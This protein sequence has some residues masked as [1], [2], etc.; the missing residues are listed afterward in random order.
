MRAQNCS[1]VRCF[2]T[3]ENMI[4]LNNLYKSYNKKAVINNLSLHISDGETVALVGKNG[5]GKTTLIRLISGTVKPDS[6][7]V[8]YEKAHSIGVLLGGDINLYGNLTGF[9]ILYYFGE[10]YGMNSRRIK[11]RISELDKEL[12]IKHYLT[13]KCHTFSRGMKQKVAFA[14]SVMHNP[15]ILLLDEPSTGLDI[16]ASA[17]VISFINY[18]KKDGKTILLVSHN[19]YEISELSDKIVFLNNGKIEKQI[20]A[21][22]F[23]TP[24]A[25]FDNGI[26]LKQ[27]LK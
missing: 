18:L 26:L 1:C 2:F 8:S 9:E 27:E 24:Y 14:I 3:G 19:V 11:N 17:D 10:L 25:D 7:T 5:A 23:F 21:K 12:N 6:G 22:D 20:E 13:K 15:D 16:E 4:E